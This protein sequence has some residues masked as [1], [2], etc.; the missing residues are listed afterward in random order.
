[1]YVLQEAKRVGSD[2]LKRW[3]GVVEC[4]FLNGREINPLKTSARSRVGIVFVSFELVDILSN[5]I[6]I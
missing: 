3:A 4:K 6:Y 2:I 5:T 1:M